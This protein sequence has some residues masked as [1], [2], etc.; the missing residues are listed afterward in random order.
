MQGQLGELKLFKLVIIDESHNLRNDQGSRYKAIKNYLDENENKVILLS[1]T[2]YNK[3]FIDLSNQLRLFLSNDKDIG[4]SPER[5]IADIGGQVQ[6]MADHTETFIR[7]IKAF[8]F[9]QFSDDWRE[10]MRLYLGR[11]TRSFIKTNY[12]ETDDI[13]G[14]IGLRFHDGHL[15]AF[16]ERVPKRVEYEF[17]PNDKKDIYAKLSSQTVVDTINHMSLPRYGLKNYLEKRPIIKAT[18]KEEIIMQNLSRAGKCLMGFCRTNLFKR[19]E[20]SG[21]SFLLSLSRHILRN[22]VF[23]YAIE[24]KQPLPI[25]KSITHNLDEF[26]EDSDTDQNENDKNYLKLILDPEIYLKKEE[27]LYKVFRTP[28]NEKHFDWIRAEFF[29]ISLQQTL[30]SDGNDIIKILKMGKDWMS[31]LQHLDKKLEI[32]P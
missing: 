6:F 28:Q 19:L 11:R 3:S 5:Y 7:S 17:N 30:I 1:A 2:P 14:K 31:M 10:L 24:N 12:G 4:N 13:T 32:L 29:F 8:E 21:Y 22:Y 26:L 9:S 20:S 16:P 27:E 25:G 18:E 15:E 23:V